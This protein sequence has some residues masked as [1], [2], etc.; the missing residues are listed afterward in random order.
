[1]TT[2][3]RYPEHKC[4]LQSLFSYLSQKI[5]ARIV[6]VIVATC[7]PAATIEIMFTLIGVVA[8]PSVQVSLFHWLVNM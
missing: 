7:G 5:L 6:A 2:G 1:M 3:Y 4:T 8:G